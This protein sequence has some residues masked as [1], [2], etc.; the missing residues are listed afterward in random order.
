MNELNFGSDK[1]ASVSLG[2]MV[3]ICYQGVFYFQNVILFDGTRVN[4][5]S[6]LY[7]ISRSSQMFEA[8]CSD[9]LPSFTQIGK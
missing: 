8:L 2:D 9:L 5:R 7:Q 4:V 6:F 3:H 1:S